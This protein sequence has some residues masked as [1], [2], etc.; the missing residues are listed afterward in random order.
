MHAIRVIADALDLTLTRTMSVTHFKMCC[1]QRQIWM[2]SPSNDKESV[3]LSLEDIENANQMYVLLKM[4]IHDINTAMKTQK[5][6]IE[7]ESLKQ[8]VSFHEAFGVVSKK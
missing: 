8:L 3:K 6:S 7:K 2:P 1:K 4:D 5:A